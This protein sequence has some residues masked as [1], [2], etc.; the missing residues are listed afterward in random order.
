MC[1]M[2]EHIL[3][4]L[5]KR[6][7]RA[8]NEWSGDVAAFL[9]PVWDRVLRKRGVFK[10]NTALCSSRVFPRLSRSRRSLTAHHAS[11]ATCS[12]GFFYFCVNVSQCGPNSLSILNR[13]VTSTELFV[14][15][16]HLVKIRS[17][18]YDQ[19]QH[20]SQIRLYWIQQ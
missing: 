7:A 14:I 1:S 8:S 2:Y 19:F 9:G 13:G 6:T 18:N 20:T 10:R 4:R 5:K 11:D 17:S 3:H 12:A 16:S 15:A